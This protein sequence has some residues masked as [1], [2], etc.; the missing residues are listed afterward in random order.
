MQKQFE[1]TQQFRGA[2]LGTI[3]NLTDEQLLAIPEGFKNNILWNLGHMIV[4]HQFFIYAPAGLDVNI[5]EEMAASFSRCTSPSDW[6]S[7]PDIAEI[8]ALAMSTMAI[9]EADIKANKF[10]NYGGM[11]VGVQLETVDDAATFICFH[12]GEHF[13]IIKAIANLV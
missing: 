12:E 2:T 8:K 4:S 3:E 11:N 5:P 9:L 13:G 1:I 6:E 10:Q 7:T